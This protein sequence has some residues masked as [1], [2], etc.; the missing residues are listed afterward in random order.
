[1]KN[2]TKY[3]GKIDHSK[4]IHLDIWISIL[5]SSKGKLSVLSTYSIAGIISVGVALSLS[6]SI[7]S[8]WL[9]L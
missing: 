6:V 3:T 4:V 1:M 5:L 7:L 9:M 8:Y 2:I